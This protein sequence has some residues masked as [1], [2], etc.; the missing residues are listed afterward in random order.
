MELGIRVGV[1][2]VVVD[3]EQAPSRNEGCRTFLLFLLVLG[4]VR[5]DRVLVT[6]RETCSLRKAKSTWLGSLPLQP[7]RRRI[8]WGR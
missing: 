2:V 8:V 7:Q 3:K 5:L 6:R 4:L 1:K